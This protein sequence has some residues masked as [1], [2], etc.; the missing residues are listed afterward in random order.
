MLYGSPSI[1]ISFDDRALQHLQ[2]VIT[3]KLRR[4]E[5]FVFSWNDSAE[6]G[7]GRS[8]IWLDASSTLYYRFFG[9][10]VPSINREWIDALMESANSGSGLFFLPEPGSVAHTAAP[11]GRARV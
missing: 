4:R 3:A 11:A 5:S 6:V 2:I 7:S 8:S 1:E 10:R 9:S